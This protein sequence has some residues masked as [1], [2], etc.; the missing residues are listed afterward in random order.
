MKVAILIVSYQVRDLLRACLHSVFEQRDAEFEVWVADNA[1]SDGSADLVASEFPAVRL[2]RIGTNLGFAAANN[3][4]LER[5][6]GDLLLLL[7]PDTELRAGTLKALI[8]LA[9]RHPEAG[10]FGLAL[11]NPD[12]TAQPSCFAFPG[13]LN[14]CVEAFGL[15]HLSARLGYGTPSRAPVPR[16]GEGPVDWVMGA[17]MALTRP[18]YERV[19]ALDAS[20]LMYGEE[21]DWCWRARQ[22]GLRTIYSEATRIVHVGGASGEGARGALHVMVLEARIGFLKRHRGAWRAALAREVLAFGAWLRLAAWRLQALRER[23]S[24]RERTRVQLE[25]FEAVRA[26]HRRG[27]R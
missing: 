20:R 16:G 1:S 14:Q 11:S 23:P 12:G 9:A 26:W 8:E 6:T 25:R 24:L 13:V 15:Q 18:A 22:L 27:S 5:C 7:N 2:D 4:L 10:A 3:R 21:M 17:F 19:G